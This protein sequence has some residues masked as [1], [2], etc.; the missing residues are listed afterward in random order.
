MTRAASMACSIPFPFAGSRSKSIQSG[1]SRLRPREYHMCTVSTDI[2][3]SQRSASAL[4]TTR[5][6]TLPRFVVR[7]G[8]S[9]VVSQSGAFL[10]DA[11]VEPGGL[12]DALVPVLER[13]RTVGQRAQHRLGHRVVVIREVL[14]RDLV[15]RIEEAIGDSSA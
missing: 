5:C 11:L 12:V 2:C 14:F 15:A 10:A 8:V 4:S 3:A 1:S 9:I 7:V 13:Q 6:F